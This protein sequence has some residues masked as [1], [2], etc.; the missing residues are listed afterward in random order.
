M[1]SSKGPQIG[2]TPRSH[3]YLISKVFQI[4]FLVLEIVLMPWPEHKHRA[5]LLVST[6]CSHD[7]PCRPL[8]FHLLPGTIVYIL[9]VPPVIKTS[10]LSFFKVRYSCTAVLLCMQYNPS[11]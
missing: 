8:T 9:S 11:T 2:D 10:S 6:R 3:F 1:Y 4:C 7:F 5:P